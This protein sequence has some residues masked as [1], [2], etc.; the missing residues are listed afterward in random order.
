MGGQDIEG[1]GNFNQD[2]GLMKNNNM[3]NNI[4]NTGNIDEDKSRAA[5]YLYNTHLDAVKEEVELIQREGEMIG[6]LEGAIKEQ[7][8]AFMRDYFG[9]AR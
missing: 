6:A 5:E 2:D 1:M 3:D 7:D 4:M 9:K 8:Y